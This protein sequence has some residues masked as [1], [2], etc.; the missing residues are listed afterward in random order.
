MIRKRSDQYSVMIFYITSLNCHIALLPINNQERR[1]LIRHELYST[2]VITFLH[3]DE[4]DT[5]HFIRKIWNYLLKHYL[6]NGKRMSP[7]GAICHGLPIAPIVWIEQKLIILLIKYEKRQFV[8][9]AAN[10]QNMYDRRAFIHIL[11]HCIVRIYLLKYFCVFSYL[12]TLLTKQT[13]H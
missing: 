2:P 3:L 4:R 5:L 8:F 9:F 10:I 11:I 6:T 1:P 7:L 13:I 12:F